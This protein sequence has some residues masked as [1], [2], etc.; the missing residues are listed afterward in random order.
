MVSNQF[1]D[2]RFG[3]A[4]V[5]ELSDAGMPQQMGVKALQVSA[6]GVV[7][8]QLLDTVDRERVAACAT[9][10]CDKD[11]RFM[12]RQVAALVV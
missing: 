2:G 5:N 1:T 10:E 8:Q 12:G 3:H 4:G 11:M 9:F 7:G 6:L